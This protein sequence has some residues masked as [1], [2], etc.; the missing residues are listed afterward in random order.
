MFHFGLADQA[1][2]FL[3]FWRNTTMVDYYMIKPKGE[4]KR[5]YEYFLIDGTSC[6]TS[7]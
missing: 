4:L 7:Q 5:L 1:I 3:T 2:F 6:K